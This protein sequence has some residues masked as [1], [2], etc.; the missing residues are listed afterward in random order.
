MSDSPGLIVLRKSLGASSEALKGPIAS[1]GDG[2]VFYD[3]TATG[4]QPETNLSL[5]NFPSPEGLWRVGGSGRGLTPQAE[6]LV[7]R[8]Y[9]DDGSGKGSRLWK[10]WQKK[11]ILYLADRNVLVDRTMANDF[12]QGPGGWNRTKPWRNVHD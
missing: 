1:N 9:H 10:A 8:P 5:E 12:R 11:R 6:E 2:F 3:R 7:R 4:A